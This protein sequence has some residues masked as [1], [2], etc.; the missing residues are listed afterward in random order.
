MDDLGIPA[1]GAHADRALRLQHQHL[2]TRHGQGAG[3]GETDD[4]GS[5]DDAIDLISHVP[6]G[7]TGADD[8]ANRILLT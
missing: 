8:Y 4:S 1:A 6:I 3:N 5:N 7:L 2:A